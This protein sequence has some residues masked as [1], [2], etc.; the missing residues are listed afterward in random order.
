MKHCIEIIRNG[1]WNLVETARAVLPGCTLRAWVLF[2]EC[3]GIYTWLLFSPLYKW[4]NVSWMALQ[5][6]RRTRD[7]EV[8]GS[9]LINR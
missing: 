9:N 5:L 8:M 7:T 4:W 3:Y 2:I 6:E 1:S